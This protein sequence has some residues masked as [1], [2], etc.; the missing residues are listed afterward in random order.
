MTDRNC[1]ESSAPA[2]GL[3]RSVFAH[4]PRLAARL[5][6]AASIVSLTTSLPGA[7]AP[8]PEISAS[9]SP[10]IALSAEELGLLNRITWGANPSSAR[11]LAKLGVS[12]FLDQQLHPPK[13]D[14][15]AGARP[16]T[17]RRA[18][19]FANAGHEARD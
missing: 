3:D 17:N 12:A 14:R 10:E 16:G 5:L 9:G 13:G 4:V 19:D 6:L 1:L 7:A 15:V 2:A 11:M 18:D 8:E